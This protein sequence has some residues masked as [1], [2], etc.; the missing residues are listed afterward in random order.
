MPTDRILEAEKIADIEMDGLLPSEV[1]GEKM[2]ETIKYAT[3]KQLH[4]LVE[5]AK[6][7]PHFIELPLDDQVALLRGGWNEL[8]IAGF[9][10][11][12]TSVTNG[13]VLANGLLVTRE[14]A[15]V[16]GLGAIFDRVLVELVSKM[17]EMQIDKTELGCLRAIVLYNPDVKGLKEVTRVEQ[18]RERVYASLEEY[19]RA[20]HENE[21]GRFAKLLLRLPALRSI[22]LKCLEHLFFQKLLGDN[23]LDSFLLDL[24]EASQD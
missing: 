17:K 24:L 13:I 7:I 16:S 4:Q 1:P 20:T 3:Q 22:G 15:H 8:M 11:R 12:S 9:S 23:S 14:N 10:H 19:C 21:T 18:Y 6:H 2:S 5:W